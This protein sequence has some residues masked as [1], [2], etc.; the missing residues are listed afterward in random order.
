MFVGFPAASRLNC[1]TSISKQQDQ[2]PRALS[3]DFYENNLIIYLLTLY[4]ISL[5]ILF[6]IC[7]FILY[8]LHN[9]CH[10][11][12]IGMFTPLGN[13]ATYI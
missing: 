12:H 11:I 6:V 1:I 7:I 5:F 3:F 4:Q 10:R 9:P 13:R 8:H 2:L